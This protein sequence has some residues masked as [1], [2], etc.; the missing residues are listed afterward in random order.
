MDPFN[1]WQRDRSYAV[2]M[3]DEHGDET[4]VR[5]EGCDGLNPVYDAH[6]WFCETCRAS[7]E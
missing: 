7:D 4:V 3:T 2:T 5:C 1:E 6:G